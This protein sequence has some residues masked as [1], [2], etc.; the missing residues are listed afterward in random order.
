VS[1][2]LSQIAEDELSGKIGHK[3]K[4]PH[5]PGKG[6]EAIGKQINRALPNP[7]FPVSRREVAPVS[8]DI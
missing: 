7:M 6:K 8:P 5:F 1:Y 3:T 2:S 4:W